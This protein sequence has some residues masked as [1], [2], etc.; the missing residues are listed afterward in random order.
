MHWV[1][2][3]HWVPNMQ[4]REYMSMFIIYA[5]VKAKE[6][7]AWSVQPKYSCIKVDLPVHDSVTCLLAELPH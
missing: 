5:C 6:S 3:M 2:N 1:R 4:S 7:R